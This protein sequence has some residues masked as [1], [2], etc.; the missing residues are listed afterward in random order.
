[1]KY[2]N[3]LSPPDSYRIG[4]KLNGKNKHRFIIFLEEKNLNTRAQNIAPLQEFD[5]YRLARLP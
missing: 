2:L 3:S 4:A 1:M 5:L